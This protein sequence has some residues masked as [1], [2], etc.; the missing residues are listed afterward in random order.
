MW[1]L[2]EAIYV[3]GYSRLGQRVA[4]AMEQVEGWTYTEYEEDG[5]TP[6]DIL[7]GLSSLHEAVSRMKDRGVVAFAMCPWGQ[8]KSFLSRLHQALSEGTQVQ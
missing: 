5:Q 3:V 7:D 4:T 8:S 6:V 2:Y 1:N